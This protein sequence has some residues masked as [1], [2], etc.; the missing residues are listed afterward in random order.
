MMKIVLLLLCVSVGY[1][2]VR[3]KYTGLN[4]RNAKGPQ[5]DG[6]FST[7]GPCGGVSTFGAN[8]VNKIAPGEEVTMRIAYNGGHKSD[9]NMFT[10]AWSCTKPDDASVFRNG[11]LAMKF[12][13]PL[14]HPAADSSTAGYEFKFNIPTNASALSC[15]ASALDQRNWGGC[16]DFEVSALATSPTS[17]PAPTAAGQTALSMID[18]SGYVKEWD[19]T[20]QCRGDSTDCCCLK[21]GAGVTH[22][23][24]STEGKFKAIVRCFYPQLPLPDKYTDSTKDLLEKSMTIEADLMQESTT[25]AGLKGTVQ[26]ANQMFEISVF[27]KFLSLANV[28]DS[29]QICSW[30]P[31]MSMTTTLPTDLYASPPPQKQGTGVGESSSTSSL[32]SN[33]VCVYTVVSLS[34]LHVLLH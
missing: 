24:G 4:I 14:Q 18:L 10:M 25:I 29:P 23:K 17:A 16:V 33:V 28:D 15:T 21:G 13:T 19:M 31:D 5:S 20:Q 30:G 27:D 34:T 8:G 1:C 3:L 6:S 26:I 12:S 32:F 2:H 22:E 9:K 7:R 11:A